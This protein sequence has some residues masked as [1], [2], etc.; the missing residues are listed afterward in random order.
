MPVCLALSQLILYLLPYF[1]DLVVKRVR[2]QTKVM[3]ASPSIKKPRLVICYLYSNERDTVAFV[4]IRLRTVHFVQAVNCGM[5]SLKVT[6]LPAFD[7]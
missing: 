7:L 4:H 2:K 6:L 1:L 3:S 5:T